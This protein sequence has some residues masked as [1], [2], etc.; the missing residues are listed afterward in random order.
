M[1]PEVR[2]AASYQA[3]LDLTVDTAQQGTGAFSSMT[4]VIPSF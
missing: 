4:Y 3:H 1:T 2:I